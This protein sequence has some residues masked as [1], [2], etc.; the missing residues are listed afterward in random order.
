[1]GLLIFSNPCNPT[2]LVLGREDVRRLVGSVEGLV[3]LDE[4]YMDFSS[5]SLL[6]EEG[7]FDNL[8]ILRTAFMEV[9]ESLE[10]SAKLDGANEWTIMFRIIVPLSKA[11]IAVILLY[12]AVGIWNSWFPAMIYLKDRGKFPLQ[13]ILREI[14]LL[15]DTQVMTSSAD[16]VKNAQLERKLVK[17]CTIVVSTLPIMCFYP[18]IQK[19]FTK[20]VMIG[21]VK[22]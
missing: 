18:F 14:L 19:Y 4:A 20:G 5:Q 15:N 6:G 22:G 21:A 3:A 7:A 11:S 12:Y 17:Y 13:L 2:S 16:A 1:M 9:P 8:I 10:E